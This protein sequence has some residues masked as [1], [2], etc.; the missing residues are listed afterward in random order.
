[1]LIVQN[2]RDTATPL[3]GAIGLRRVLGA[4]A[5]ML[6]VDQ[7]GHTAYLVTDSSCANEKTTR[8]LV[9]GA[10]PSEP[11]LCAGQPLPA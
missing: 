1:V 8:Y 2:L 6:T 4:G 11:T 7:G 10:L 5:V 3:A 9:H